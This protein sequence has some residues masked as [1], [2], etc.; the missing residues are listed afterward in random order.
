MNLQEALRTFI[1]IFHL[2]H[3]K[4][5]NASRSICREIQNTF[6]VA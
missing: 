5:R 3:F 6:Y 1:I 2:I 4:A